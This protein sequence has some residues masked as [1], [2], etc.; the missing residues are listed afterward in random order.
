M[1]SDG[2]IEKA[3][4]VW[5]EYKYRHEHCWKLIFQITVAVVVV[6]IVPYTNE[7]IAKVLGYLIV[8][9]PVL[10]II[11]TL[12]S[13]LRVKHELVLWKEI[14]DKHTALQ[15]NLGILE[16]KKSPKSTFRRDVLIYLGILA[17]LGIINC[18]AIVFVWIPALQ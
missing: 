15:I 18:V 4:L 16:N 7:K 3:N 1:N 2:N 13:I 9:L 14:R 8:S 5:D 17:F 12:F 6:S 10:G 11:L